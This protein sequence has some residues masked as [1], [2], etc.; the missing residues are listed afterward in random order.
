MADATQPVIMCEVEFKDCTRIGSTVFNGPTETKH[1]DNSV[2]RYPAD[3]AGLPLALAKIVEDKQ[4][5]KI[6]RQGILGDEEHGGIKDTLGI[7]KDPWAD[8][9]QL[10]LSELITRVMRLEDENADL[11]TKLQARGKN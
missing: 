1:A 6:L 4:L 11:K 2:T 5:G 9:R 3:R 7:G 10:G 8:G